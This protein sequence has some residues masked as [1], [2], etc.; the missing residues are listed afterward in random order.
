LQDG[1]KKRRQTAAVGRY[2]LAGGRRLVRFEPRQSSIDDRI[3]LDRQ[4]FVPFDLRYVA[5]D[6]HLFAHM[7]QDFDAGVG[8]FHFV[9]RAVPG[10]IGR[11]AIG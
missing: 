4:V 3:G 2:A 8:V 11:I 9:D 6:L 10:R 5:D 7:R 1:G